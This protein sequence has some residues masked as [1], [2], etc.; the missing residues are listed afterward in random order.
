MLIVVDPSDER[1]NFF[2][3]HDNDKAALSK[4]AEKV[5]LVSCK[6]WLCFGL[7]AIF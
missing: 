3:S 6:I 4:M 7:F 2:F 1:K 5:V